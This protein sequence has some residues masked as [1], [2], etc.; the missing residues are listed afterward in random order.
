MA[1]LVLTWAIVHPGVGVSALLLVPL[2]ADGTTQMCTAYESKNLRRLWTGT[3]FGYGL[4]NL[5][6]LSAE[7]VFRWGYH[8]GLMLKDM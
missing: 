8:V 1:A 2:V 7:G 3:L 5:I 6:F 4:A